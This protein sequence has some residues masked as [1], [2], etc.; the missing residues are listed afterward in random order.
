MGSL[1]RHFK[2]AHLIFAFTV[3]AALA[4]YEAKFQS[5]APANPERPSMA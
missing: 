3:N 5:E 2:H 4:G 1:W